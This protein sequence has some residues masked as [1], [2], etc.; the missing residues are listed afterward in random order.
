MKLSPGGPGPTY[1]SHL[2]ESDITMNLFRLFDKWFGQKK[3]ET[4]RS[5]LSTTAHRARRTLL[6]E[7]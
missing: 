3:T 4:A 1:L 7:G 5:P 2:H 6:M